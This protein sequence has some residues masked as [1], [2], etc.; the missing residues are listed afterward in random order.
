MIPDGFPERR[1]AQ[2]VADLP[3]RVPRSSSA[4]AGFSMFI[5]PAKREWWRSSRSGLRERENKEGY[6]LRLKCTRPPKTPAQAKLEGGHSREWN[7]LD[8]LG[9]PP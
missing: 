3:Q 1:A 8:W 2:A 6:F 9:Y 4:W 5:R 7:A